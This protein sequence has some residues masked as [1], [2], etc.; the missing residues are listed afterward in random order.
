MISNLRRSKTEKMS[1]SNNCSPLLTKEGEITTATSLQDSNGHSCQEDDSL[2]VARRPGIS[3][4][5]KQ[6]NVAMSE[7]IRRTKS[8]GREALSTGL[9]RRGCSERRTN[10]IT[11]QNTEDLREVV[12]FPVKPYYTDE[13]DHTVS[14]P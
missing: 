2:I 9:L 1:Q 8:E 4:K 7:E 11:R 3:G 12:D 5:N 10:Y 6:S 13:S 14:I